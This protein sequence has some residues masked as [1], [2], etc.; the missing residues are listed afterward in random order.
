MCNTKNENC[1]HTHI[2][3]HTHMYVYI[4]N[5]KIEKWAKGC[6]PKKGNLRITKN[7]T[8]ISLTAIA[9][10]VYNTLILNCIRTDIEKIL[11]QNQNK[12]QSIRLATTPR[13]SPLPSVC[14]ICTSEKKQKSPISYCHPSALMSL[15]LSHSSLWLFFSKK[16]YLPLCL[17]T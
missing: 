1:T 6:I 9:A 8:G 7:Y 12:K 17:M 2:H 10:K 4:I 11:S 3:T 16:F 13:R 15:H 14:C 5:I